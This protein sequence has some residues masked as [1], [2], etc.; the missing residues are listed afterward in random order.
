MSQTRT[1]EQEATWQAVA[2]RGP[3]TRPQP[4]ARTCG[5]SPDRRDLGA[6]HLVRRAD[7]G[8]DEASGCVTLCDGCHAAR[9]PRLQVALSRRM[10]ERWALRLAAWLDRTGELPDETCALAALRLFGACCFARRLYG[11]D[12]AYPSHGETGVLRGAALHVERF[13]IRPR[14]G[15]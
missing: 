13:D 10:M 12:S 5:E 11:D 14:S 4:A 2:A 6:N 15:R 8:R 7:G 3:R 1:A 9:H